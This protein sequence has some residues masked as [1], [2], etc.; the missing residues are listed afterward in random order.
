ML[1]LTAGPLFCWYRLQDKT[2]RI[3]L[4]T[5]Y[6][7]TS[8]SEPV[9]LDLIRSDA[10]MRLK[11]I[12]QYGITW[13]I[14]DEYEYTRYEHSLGVFYLVRKY[15]APLDEQVAALL[16]D[17]SHTVFS[18]V[19]DYIYGHIRSEKVMQDEMHEQYIV[20]SG[21]MK[22]LKKYGFEH[23]ITEEAKKLQ[24]C[25]EQE[26]PDICAD[27]L[28]YVLNGA[29]FDG[30]ISEQEL[31]DMLQHIHFKN[32]T[33]FFD[34]LQL[35]KKYATASVQLPE[36]RWGAA[37]H[38]FTYGCMG[39]ALVRALK[40]GLVTFNE[41]KFSTDDVVWNKIVASSDC[42]I[43]LQ[44]KRLKN[45]QTAFK[46]VAE[47]QA[48]SHII[49]KFTGQDPWVMTKTG[50]QRLSGIDSGFAEYYQRVSALQKQGYWIQIQ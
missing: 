37:W 31:R 21:L 50:L 2:D 26:K 22:I 39:K 3:E 1:A 36:M 17:V 20:E 10:F 45:W 43:Q 28:E 15:G 19:G 9:L 41:I 48:D 7:A 32:G 38:A 34:D 14:R 44:I 23:A 12:R 11:Q 35:A 27:R 33:W 4:E 24:P 6:G 46:V 16:H 29:S 40:I 30:I 18:H 47:D 8:I 13:F 42:D 25:F 5:M 49:G